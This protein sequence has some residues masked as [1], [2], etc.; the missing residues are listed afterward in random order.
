MAYANVKNAHI[1]PRT[2]LLN[3][4]LDGRIGVHLVEDGR[5]L[6]QPVEKVGTRRRFYRRTRPADGTPI[7]DVEWSLGQLEH[8]VAPTLRE[9]DDR[10]P[11]GDDDKA[12]LA[13]LFAYQLIRGPRYKTAFE[14]MT[15]RFLE[16][17]KERE[18]F[19]GVDPEQMAAFDEALKGDTH[20]LTRMLMMGMTLTSILI[21]THWT[22]VEFNS[23]VL[24]TCDEP[25]VIWPGSGPRVPQ[26][27]DL[28]GDGVL[29][30]IEY[31][32]PLSP[33]RGV[34]MTW[35]D[36]PDDEDARVSGS[37]QHA[38]NFNA[39]TMA[40]ADRQWFFQ[41]G[42]SPPRSAGRVRPLSLE[43]VR[44]YTPDAAAKSQRH[45]QVSAHVQEKV[46]RELSDREVVRVTVQQGVRSQPSRG[47]D[48]QR[49][50]SDGC[51]T[52]SRWVPRT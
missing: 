15:E 19:D 22:L 21:S 24:A 52:S 25:V 23:P 43:L 14:E 35:A 28:L 10:W 36:K 44:G 8:A 31:R 33:T 1:V 27:A 30:C 47:H 16:E 7:D 26:A 46:G 42:T 18:D 40:N 50:G 4:A 38:M 32:L 39:F 2:Y 34:L 6:V 29:N 51:T 12:K 9:F 11:L 49:V 37:Y 5:E 13:Q 3:F 41:P 20:R 45:A 48:V 17:Y